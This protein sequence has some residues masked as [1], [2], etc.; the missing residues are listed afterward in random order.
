MNE[1]IR[2]TNAN[3]DKYLHNH[4]HEGVDSVKYDILVPIKD[5]PVNQIRIPTA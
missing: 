1:R 5:I 3:I 2:L 4:E